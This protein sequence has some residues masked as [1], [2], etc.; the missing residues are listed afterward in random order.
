MLE[1]LQSVLGFVLAIGILVTFH[2]FGHYWVARRCGVRVL[3]FSIGFGKPLWSRVAADGTRWQVAAIPLGGY[4]KMLDEREAP[5]SAEEQ[6]FAFNRKPVAQR[7]AI[8]AAGPVANFLL[9]IVFYALVQMIGQPALRPV[10]GPVSAESVAADAGL[11]EGDTLVRI[12]GQSVATWDRA[13]LQLLQASLGAQTLEVALR[14]ASGEDYAATLPLA[15][16][17]SEPLEFF[18]YLGLVP[19]QVRLEP[20]LGQ[21]LDGS[22]A[23]RAGLQVGDRITR[24]DAR[25]VASWRALVTLIRERPA[26]EVRLGVQRADAELQVSLRLAEV[27][28][29]QGPVGQLGAG[30]AEQA[31]LWQDFRFIHRLGPFQSVLAGVEQTLNMSVLTVKMLWRMVL[32]E[33]SVK[34]LSGPLSIAEFAGVS[35]A[36][37][38]VSFLGFLALISV[39]LGVLNLLPVPV[40][41]GGHLLYYGIEAVKGSPLSER[42]QSLGHS[43]GLAMLLGLMMVALYNDLTRLLS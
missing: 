27:M 4:V 10:L 37:G 14:R 13:R 31:H 19:P 42:V 9:A 11:Q 25:E 15:S 36:A 30:V 8:V 35:A 24:L 23:D 34:N 28:T 39:S 41:D 16:A 6:P 1:L 38:V 32:G 21:I 40:L 20:I 26:E 17:P 2:E 43:V 3:C 22:P 18:D 33:V 12:A 29:E 5:V 7:I